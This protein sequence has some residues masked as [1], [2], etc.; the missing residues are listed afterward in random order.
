MTV[1]LPDGEI[2]LEVVVEP[3]ELEE[4]DLDHI[5]MNINTA[6]EYEKMNNLLI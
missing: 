3:E 6:E 2:S 4:F 5:L 1:L